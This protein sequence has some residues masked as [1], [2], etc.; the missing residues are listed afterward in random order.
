VFAADATRRL[1]EPR[2]PPERMLT[3]PYGMEL[4]EIARYSRHF[5][6]AAARERLGI[7]EDATVLLCL[8][9]IEP[10]KGQALLAQA[11]A[12][13][14][15]AHPDAQLVLVGDQPNTY[16]A[17]L[18]E[19]LERSEVSDR[20]RVVGLVA[21]PYEWHGI[22]DLF[23]LASDVES[24]PIVIL[25]AM[26]FETP[27]VAT[28]VFGVPELIEDGVNG[29]LCEPSD[30]D[31]LAGS[32]DRALSESPESRRRVGKAGAQGI[33]ARHDPGTYETRMRSLM[34]GL[35]ADP[36]A[37]PAQLLSGRPRSGVRRSVPE[38]VSV[39]IPTL[40]AGEGFE[41]SLEAIWAQEGL[42]GLE[43]VV[44]DSGSSD[45][46]VSLARASGARVREIPAAEFNHGRVRNQLAEMATGDVLC[47]TVQDALPVGKHAIRDLVLALRSDSRLAAVSARQIAGA[48]A[49]LYS[50]FLSW[51]RNETMPLRENFPAGSVA[52][53]EFLVDDVCA[54]VRLSAWEALRFRELSYGEDLDFGIRANN[55]GWRTCFADGAACS[56][57]HDRDAAHFL[58]RA[59]VHRSTLA[60]LL[61]DLERLPEAQPGL[62]ALTAEMPGVLGQLEAA[63]SQAAGDSERVLLAPYVA[64]VVDR[65]RQDPQPLP[66]TGELAGVAA[67]FDDRVSWNDMVQAAR[68]EAVRTGLRRWI[69]YAL[70]F[71]WVRQYALAHSAPVARDAAQAFV[72]RCAASNLGQV[73]GD[74]MRDMPETPVSQ[75]VATGAWLR[76]VSG[77]ANEALSR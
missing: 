34:T 7:P 15:E 5:D 6:P 10:R 4:D 61:K 23:V 3:L 73:V 36:E 76:S 62:D 39:L 51:R 44:A 72:A 57:H 19:Y 13:V 50:K 28:G 60:D 45:Q 42:G 52:W 66:P 2:C 12:R 48:D 56:H 26:A 21:D 77:R 63:V 16:S 71:G 20:I 46:T 8:G 17:G 75:R 18:H 14:C 1:Y 54:A 53:S 74:A 70:E 64:S 35:A 59:A 43:V 49:D 65:L 55:A 29:Y 40:D 33:R 58:S 69:H 22:A 24:S 32:L 31:S 9:T 67:L 37:L 41:R 47:T 68:N 38:R 30:L 11:F 27:V 25:E